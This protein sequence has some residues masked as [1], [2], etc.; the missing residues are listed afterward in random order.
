M[1]YNSVSGCGLG[2]TMDLHCLFF[3]CGIECPEFSF[4]V[5]KILHSFSKLPTTARLAI[6]LHVL[7][8]TY[9]KRIIRICD[10]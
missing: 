9:N 1:Q 2:P 3:C 8:Q 10:Q 5:G 4:R 7:V 6:A